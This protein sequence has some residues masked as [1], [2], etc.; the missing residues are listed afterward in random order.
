MALETVMTMLLYVAAGWIALVAVK[1]LQTWWEEGRH[2]QF[3]TGVIGVVA[4]TIAIAYLAWWPRLTFVNVA[5]DS[6]LP[7]PNNQR[8]G[9]CPP[10]GDRGGIFVI[11]S[12]TMQ[13]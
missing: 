6:A 7:V 9:H 11:Q 10:L 12:S 3:V 2:E 13:G 8:L 5:M 1:S 4:A